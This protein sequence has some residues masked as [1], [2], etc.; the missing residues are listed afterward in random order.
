MIDERRSRRLDRLVEQRNELLAALDRLDAELARGEI[1]EADHAALSDDLTRRAARIIRRID[2]VDPAPKP[3]DDR[4]TTKNVIVVC[5]VAVAAIALGFVV[6]SFSGDRGSGGATGEIAL[7]SRDFLGR[8]EI[9]LGQG[10]VDEAATAVGE[11]L[12]L[13]PGDPDALVMQGR[14]LQSQGDVVGAVQSFDQALA[15]EPDNFG[16][17][18]FKAQILIRVPDPDIQQQAIELLDAAI[19]QD[20]LTFEAHMWRGFAAANVE[21]DPEAAIG[22]YEGVLERN[23]PE[24]MRSVVEGLIDELSAPAQP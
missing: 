10:R 22:Y 16:A 8:A 4:S 6:A 19:A 3:A 1:D 5:V 20:P 23:P 18:V 21:N 11:A 14:V 17:L 12:A 15:V 9:A 2:D 24:A 7:S 13:V